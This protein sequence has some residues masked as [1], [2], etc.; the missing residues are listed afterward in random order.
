MFSTLRSKV[1]FLLVGSIIAISTILIIYSYYYFEGENENQ[2]AREFEQFSSIFETEVVNKAM[3]QAAALELLAND[4]VTLQLFAENRRDELRDKLLPIFEN[5]L[6]PIYKI[7]QVH[8]HTAD[9]RS[10][11]RLHKPSKF[12]DDLSGFRAT[13]VKANRERTIVQ[14]IEVGKY[15]TGLRNVTPLYYEG[16]HIGSVEFSGSIYGLLD[17]ISTSLDIQYAIGVDHKYLKIAGAK[18]QEHEIDKGN[19]TYYYFSDQRLSEIL[20]DIEI[21]RDFEIYDM[22]KSDIAVASVPIKDYNGDDVGCITLFNDVSDELASMNNTIL[23][24]III[25]GIITIIISFLAYRFLAAELLGPLNAVSKAAAR[26]SEGDYNFKLSVKKEDEIGAVRNS[27]NQMITNINKK[28]K[29]L[30]DEKDSIQ[31][32]IDEA[33]EQSEKDKQYLADKTSHLLNAMYEFSSGDLTVQ[34][35]IEKDDEIG[36]LYEGFNQSVLRIHELIE[37]VKEAVMSTSSASAQISS[38]S[39]EMAAGAQEQSFRTNEVA[40]AVEQ[41]TATIVENSKNTEKA[42]LSVKNAGDTA[43]SGG[44]VVN[45]TVNA[46]SNIAEVINNAVTTVSELGKSTDQIG[47]I[48]QVIDEI[49]DQTN[50]LALNAAIEAARAGEE[51]RGFA[52]VADEVRKLAERTSKA[53]KEISD[54]IKHIQTRTHV[55]VTSIESGSEIVKKGQDMANEAGTALNGIIDSSQ[56]AV[57]S[58]DKVARAS[59]EQARTV[60]DVGRSIESINTVISENSSGIQQIAQTAEDLNRLTENLL[61]M[62]EIFK[63]AKHSFAGNNGQQTLLSSN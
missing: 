56:E 49:A 22:L 11:L 58:V 28:N 45:N 1:T 13:V 52:V 44:A 25:I 43:K 27:M 20:P 31:K 4:P 54:M 7:A 42:K 55:V 32:R 29:E 37:R 48:I 14:G 51:G 61:N 47:A 62:V 12:G 3:D 17:A 26:I 60:E 24:T 39:E 59:E 23:M 21:K 16:Q 63:L 9:N 50:L 33:V 6:K 35:K 41:L 15:G 30:L 18:K 57:N 40:G 53:T 36:K 8:F 46:M 38:S 2:I 34:L 19:N 5:K 10:F